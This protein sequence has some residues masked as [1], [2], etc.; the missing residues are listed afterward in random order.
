MLVRMLFGMRYID[1]Y[2][3]R[4]VR[5]LRTNQ[6]EGLISELIVA[7]REAVRLTGR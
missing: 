3:R 5:E 4:Q 2:V 1:R 7:E 6:R